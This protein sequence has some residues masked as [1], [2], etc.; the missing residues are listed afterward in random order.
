MNMRNRPSQCGLSHLIFVRSTS[1]TQTTNSC[2]CG[3]SNL[4]HVNDHD[5]CE[6][7]LVERKRVLETIIARAHVSWLRFCESFP[8][9]ATLLRAADRMG[10]EGI[11]CNAHRR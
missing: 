10:L 1:A 9:G 8:D 7:P 3:R 6:Q 4:L 11:V 2:A 5:L